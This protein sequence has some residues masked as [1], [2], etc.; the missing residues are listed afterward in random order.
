[1]V[2]ISRALI[3]DC[4]GWN[5][6]I[7]A[8]AAEFAVSQLP[9]RL[10]GKKV[11][12]IGAGN[13]SSISP[14]FA[15]KGADLLCSYY[16]W[17]QQRDVEDGQLRAVTAK[18]GLGK[19]LVEEHDIHDLQGIYDIIVMKSVLGGI[20][21]NENY[22]KLKLIIDRLWKNN[23]R[24][25]GYVV[26]LD[27]GYVRLFARLRNLWGAGKGGW[28]YFR[29][30]KLLA[31]LSDYDVQI[32]GF[33]LI[34]VGAVEFLFVNDFLYLVDKIALSLI[35]LEDRAVLSTVIRKTR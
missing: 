35:D 33:G 34:N 20:C 16:G 11:L 27:N 10:D 2:N 23:L 15:S 28:T 31:S 29:R 24:R 8:D 6:K 14:I 9:E 19:I 4:C 13:Y 21:E 7:W 25:G 22:G 3:E 12:E 18:Y 1:M 17:H 30:N 26:S 5:R 32:R